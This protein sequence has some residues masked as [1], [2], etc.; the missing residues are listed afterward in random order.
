MT[1]LPP[2]LFGRDWWNCRIL[3]PRDFE[4]IEAAKWLF[5]RFQF[6]QIG[7]LLYPPFCP[8]YVFE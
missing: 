6:N 7:L 8:A 5:I 3:Y 2:Y 4:D 1:P